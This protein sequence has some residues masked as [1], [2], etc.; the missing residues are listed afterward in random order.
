MPYISSSICGIASIQVTRAMRDDHGK[1]Y[2]SCRL[3]LRDQHGNYC[4]EITLLSEAGELTWELP[5]TP[6]EAR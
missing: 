3:T 5:K 2:E 1:P 6:E 4:G